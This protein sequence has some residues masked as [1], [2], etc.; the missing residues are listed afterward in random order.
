[1]INVIVGIPII[2]IGIYFSLLPFMPA[3]SHFSRGFATFE[4]SW[5][6]IFLTTGIIAIIIGVTL[7]L[8]TEASDATAVS[9]AA[10]SGLLIAA[11]YTDSVVGKVPKELSATAILTGFI[12]GIGA[13]IINGTN[14]DDY[15]RFYKTIPLVF[16]GQ[17]L[18]WLGGGAAVFLIFFLVW[19]RVRGLILSIFSMVITAMG[20]WVALTAGLSLIAKALTANFGEPMIWQ[21]ILIYGL[22]S[23][24][25]IALLTV[26]FDLGSS[27]AMGGADADSMYASSWAFGAV[28]GGIV[29]GWAVIV[30][31][32]IQLLLH[33]FA[34]PLRLVTRDKVMPNT[35][36]TRSWYRITGRR[37][38]AEAETRIAHS[39][40]FLP[41]LNIS[42]IFVTIFAIAFPGVLA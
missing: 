2:Y 16:S 22:P 32:V 1:M 36:Y 39:L 14:P 25:V 12:L 13:L 23:M 40:P 7:K 9:V 11:G 38:L 8:F 4:K 27:T 33:L 31:A 29:L 18:I 15:Q 10:V 41:V 37:E 30:A 20:L 6:N 19:F 42:V 21:N 3:W 5:K 17:E 35:F 24:L 28:V 26:A 34:K